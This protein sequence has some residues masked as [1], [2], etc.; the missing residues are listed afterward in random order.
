NMT[1]LDVYQTRV[2]GNTYLV[3]VGGQNLQEVLT[4]SITFADKQS[5]EIEVFDS[6]ITAIDFRRG[7]A[8][9]GRVL[10]DLSK[11]GM[12]ISVEQTSKE[13]KVKFADT[14]LPVDLR[15][16]LDVVDFATPVLSVSSSFDGKDT[17]V[18]IKPQ[19]EYDY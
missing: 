8:G 13:I 10:V 14:K 7:E 5:S 1:T 11:S 2:E 9:E 4:K 18:V 19:G 17:L 15:R 6:A 3:E 12:N 16:K